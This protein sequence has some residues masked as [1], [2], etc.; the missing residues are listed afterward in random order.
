MYHRFQHTYLDLR[1]PN[2]NLPMIVPIERYYDLALVFQDHKR[3]HLLIQHISN[4][5]LDTYT[6]LLH[7]HQ[8]NN[9][10]EQNIEAFVVVIELIDCHH[11]KQ[12]Q[13]WYRF[14]EQAQK[15]GV[16]I[17]C[18]LQIQ[19]VNLS[20]KLMEVIEP[21]FNFDLLC[22]FHLFMIY[23]TGKTDGYHISKKAMF[24]LFEIGIPS[25]RILVPYFQQ[26]EFK[27]Q[28]YNLG[29]FLYTKYDVRSHTPCLCWMSHIDNKTQ[30]QFSHH[31]NRREQ[32]HQS[33][34]QQQY[35]LWQQ[36]HT[37][38][39]NRFRSMETA[40]RF[41]SNQEKAKGKMRLQTHHIGI[42]GNHPHTERK[43]THNLKQNTQ[44]SAKKIQGNAVTQQ[45]RFPLPTTPIIKQEGFEPIQHN[46]S[47][48]LQEH[49]MQLQSL[50]SKPKKVNVTLS[51]PKDKHDEQP[52]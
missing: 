43:T 48:P 41:Y 26:A 19:S 11:F 40:T 29:G 46:T 44:E 27:V 17:H 10:Y 14:K 7:H 45:R 13:P 5:L 4:D 30:S 9:L 15:C 52:S 21:Y 36:Q 49:T 33:L 3:F 22:T 32:E 2:K 28:K 35:H 34:A 20:F 51:K 16:L 8:Q 31:Q 18:L 37:N 6:N 50:C 38:E 39:K 42:K 25:E 12:T 1:P 47:I 23:F 24:R